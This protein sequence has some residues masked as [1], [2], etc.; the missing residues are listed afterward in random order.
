MLSEKLIEIGVRGNGNFFV[1]ILNDFEFEEDF[2]SKL[3]SSVLYSLSE[4]LDE[5]QNK[6]QFQAEVMALLNE[7]MRGGG[8]GA[9]L[10]RIS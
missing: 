3:L 10:T 4:C 2:V 9:S 6:E 5:G 1:E 7:E 8:F